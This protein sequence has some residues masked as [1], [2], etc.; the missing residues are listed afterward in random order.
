MPLPEERF[1]G[2]LGPDLAG[3]ASR[4]SSAQI[5]LRVVDESRLNPA[6]IMPPYY[7]VEDLRR[8]LTAYRDRPVL[9]AEQVEDVVALLSTF[10]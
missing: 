6:T 7:R 5:R 8:V 1:Q 10:R 4:L 3:V 9:S 2:D